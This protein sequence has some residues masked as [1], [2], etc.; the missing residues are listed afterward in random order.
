MI[1]KVVEMLRSN[2]R[3]VFWV[4]NFLDS[5]TSSHLQHLGGEELT[6]AEDGGFN[7]R[8]VRYSL[9]AHVDCGVAFECCGVDFA[10]LL[11]SCS[12]Y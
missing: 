1:G 10:L 2:E 3:G 11:L 6:T 9:C 4:V 7:T 12:F 5:V 8:E